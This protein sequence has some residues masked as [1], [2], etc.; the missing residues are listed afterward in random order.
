MKPLKTFFLLIPFLPLFLSAQNPFYNFSENEAVI[1]KFAILSAN[2]LFDTAVYYQKKN[3]IDTALFCFNLFL[4]KPET[5]TDP[6]YQERRIEAMNKKGLIF[7]KTESFQ[8]AYNL[9][10]DALDLCEKYNNTKVKAKILNNIGNIFLLF[11][12]TGVAESYYFQTLKICEDTA[13]IIKSLLNIYICKSKNK[14]YDSTLYYLNKA[15]QLCELSNV[16]SLRIDI[17][18]SF[19]NN[20]LKQ[21]LL[22]SAFYYYKL[23][24]EELKNNDNL[25]SKAELFKHFAYYLFERKQMDSAIYYCNLSNDIAEQKFS[26]SVIA[27]NYKTLSEI[28]KSKGNYKTSLEYLE[29]HLT[30]KDSLFGTEKLLNIKQI[31]RLHEISKT[32][33]QIEQLE[34]EQQINRRTIFYQKIIWIILSFFLLLTT[35][36][37]LIIYFQKRDLNIAYKVLFDQNLAVMDPK[38]KLSEIHKE[39]YK[40]YTLA[41]ETQQALLDKILTL[42]EDTSL[43]CHVEFLVDKLAVLLESNQTYISQTI[44]MALKKNFRSLLN[45]YRIREAQRLFAEWD[46]TKYSMESIAFQVGYK[47]YSGFWRAFKEVTG[48]LPTYYVKSL[49]N[50]QESENGEE[51]VVSG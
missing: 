49:K 44:N 11:G 40:K 1:S 37:L 2:Q 6:K 5:K 23:A 25:D 38:I 42:M 43:I 13:S 8:N 19:A 14:Q 15:L 16:T 39:R 12:E 4:N 17:F 41:D 46:I 24:L 27:E 10:L 50:E 22:D 51:L 33:Q 32:N 7:V 26:L 36:G 31:Q 20:Y 47:S 28:E 9:W 18:N 21:K 34:F 3:S 35:T 29:K 48:M 45:S 30:L